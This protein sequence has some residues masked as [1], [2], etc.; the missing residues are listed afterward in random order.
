MAQQLNMVLMLLLA[1]S[2]SFLKRAK[3]AALMLL[4]VSM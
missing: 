4:T 1:L 3:A 2:T